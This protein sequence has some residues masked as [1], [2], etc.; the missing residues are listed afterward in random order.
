MSIAVARKVIPSMFILTGVLLL[1]GRAPAAPPA[2]GASA[3]PA[4]EWQ[5]PAAQ[6]HARFVQPLGAVGTVEQPP[7]DLPA[8][9]AEDQIAEQNNEAPRYAI[10]RPVRI[11]PQTN[12]T[13]EKLGNDLVLWRLRV[14]SPGAVSLNLGF[15]RYKMPPGGR[16]FLY[17]P[18][19][20]N[21]I[22]PFSDADNA[23]HNQLWT[24]P[25]PGGD[26][27]VEAMLPSRLQS[28]LDLELGSINIG[29]RRF[30]YILDP[31][32]PTPRSGSCNVDVACPEGDPWSLEIPSAAVISTGGSRFCSGS[33]LNNTAQDLTP[34]FLT[35]FH[36]GVTS[37]NAASLVCFWNYQNSTCRPVGSPAS[38]GPGDGTLTEFN[39]GST[40]RAGFSTSDFTLVQLTSLPNPAWNVSYAGWDRQGLNP[41]SGACIH[42]PNTD[43]K[44]ITFYDIAQR[45]DRPSHGSSWGCS[46]FPGPGD[47][48]HISVY[49]WLG[50]TEPGS[51][52]S[53]L[54]DDAH[55]VIG[56]LHGGPSACG[57]TGDNLSDCY[58]RLSRSW[59]GGG[60]SAT[61]LSDWLDPIASGALNV[62]TISSGGLIL[63]PNGSI[64]SIGP[65]GGP[66]SNDTTVYTI[67][68]PGTSAANYSASIVGGG[69]A[70]ILLDGGAGPV[71]GT[72]NPTESANITVTLDAAVNSL[73]AGIYST[74]VSFQDTTNSLSSTRTHVVEVGTTNFD[75]TP[76]DGLVSGGPQG[77]PFPTTK[78][79]TVTS[80]RPTPVTVRASVDQPWVSLNGGA[81]PVDMP[82]ANQGDNANVV[83]GF[84]AAA[85]SLAIGTY[86]ATVSFTN[87]SGGQGNTSRP[88]TLTVG[89][90]Q[91]VSSDVPKPIADNSSV[92]STLTVS[93]VFCIGDVNVPIDITHT[94]IG[95]L[96]V[97]LTSPSGTT[98]RLHNR[99][100]GSTDNLVQTYN[101]PATP[102][103][104]PGTLTDFVGEYSNG[105]WTLLVSDNAGADT[106][107]L[108][109]WGLTMQALGPTCPTREVIHNLP[110]DS[111]PGWSADADWAFGIPTGVGGDPTSGHTGTNVW[112]YNLA[113]QYPN[114]LTPVRNL[115]TGALD[116]T[117]VTNT[118][119]EYWRW[120]GVE[121]STYDHATVQISNNGTIW[122]TVWS[123]PGSSMNETAWTLAKHDISAIADNQPTVYIRWTMGTTDGS[124]TYQGWNIDDIQ[125]T[126]I[127]AP[128][129][130]DL[131]GDHDVDGDDQKILV[132]V[133]LGQDNDVLHK[134]RADMNGD[135]LNNADDVQ[136]WVNAAM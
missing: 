45:P 65:V 39:T 95:D 64:T 5:K 114:S 76:G 110:L 87:L 17:T 16:L 26:I 109:S 67:S 43:E 70:P 93:D 81:G 28:S 130:G 131:D 66:F 59:T 53:P 42:H 79:Y 6:T 86:N 7:I 22:R 102:A 72:L 132:A 60:T 135:G 120:L 107:T 13:W 108:N 82:L 1:Y 83:V 94:Y 46:A 15:T 3:V 121:S 51:S 58:G 36:C 85:N 88:I 136:L 98:V 105:T 18:D 44:R 115:T 124:V 96:I 90:F 71:T 133:L 37:G 8:V 73:S 32:E 55:R 4:V 48:T 23:D 111:N 10:P 100:G 27:V 33:M 14:K 99:T 29:Y 106:G 40:F 113:G 123:N 80:S 47:N 41:P 49:W 19:F 128:L 116:C 38:G 118:R 25:L 68:N 63:P 21:K 97:D 12:G 2:K 62:D 50:V 92:T 125:I 69:T 9:L 20:A 119:L 11:T 24:P 57:Q 122:T 104:G 61:R 103:D 31:N 89:S 117:G 126:G 77:G 54:F 35:A 75:T 52:G 112:G 84:S 91:Y 56:Q 127:R 129:A 30:A 34:F 134:Q 101:D 78:T 74:D